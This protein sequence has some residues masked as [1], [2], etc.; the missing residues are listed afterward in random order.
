MKF[1]WRCCFDEKKEMNEVNILH[2]IMSVC[3]AW[4]RRKML[5]TA[6]CETPGSKE[7]GE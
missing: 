2:V 6:K 5:K 3:V 1:L 4:R 7:T